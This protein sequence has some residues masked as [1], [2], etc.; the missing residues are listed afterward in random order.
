MAAS[1]TVADDAILLQRCILAAQ[2]T[3]R[4]NCAPLN[5]VRE[6]LKLLEDGK[7]IPAIAEDELPSDKIE[8][9][10]A[11]RLF[12]RDFRFYLCQLPHLL[13]VVSVLL[14]KAGEQPLKL[15]EVE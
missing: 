5:C 9:H 3:R 11:G 10:L 14:L 2:C 8:R 7:L 4:I 6:A 15:I 12:L 1:R 13:H